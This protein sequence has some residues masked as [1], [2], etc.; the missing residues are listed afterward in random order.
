M[1]RRIITALLAVGVVGAVFA[2]TALAKAGPLPKALQDVRA[3]VARYHSYDEALAAGY[4]AAAER[5]VA[6]AGLG[7]MGFHAV[8]FGL[9]QGGAIDP[10]QPPILLYAPRADGSLQLAGVE[11]W[12]IALANTDSG[13]AP[14][15]AS[16]APPNGF[17]NPAP[18]LF[19]QRFDGPMPGHNPQMPW[20]YDLHVWLFAEN[21]TG[22][23]TPFNPAIS[24]G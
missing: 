15:F 23:F 19:G 2:A 10:L 18:T 22:L 20:H 12:M 6:E 11:Y 14:W 9:L 17:F 24:C 1:H 21:P 4:S 3:S 5:C 16:T 8:N 13:P 7:T